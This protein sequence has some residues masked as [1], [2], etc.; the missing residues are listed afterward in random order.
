MTECTMTDTLT[1]QLRIF[2]EQ[3]KIQIDPDFKIYKSAAHALVD[4][5]FSSMAKFDAV[6]KPLMTRLEQHLPDRHM[7]TLSELV[8]DIDALGVEKYAKEVLNLQRISGRLK[9]QIVRDA[10]EFLISQG[11]ETKADFADLSAREAACIV[12]Y[13]L[14]DT[15]RGIGPALSR[16]L[17][18]LLGRENYIKPD[19]ILTRLLIRISVGELKPHDIKRMTDAIRTVADEMDTTPARLDNALWLYES[20]RPKERDKPN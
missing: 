16:Y 12:L 18:L 19:T 3:E 9:V 1:D 6:V 5:V 17:M 11:I 14:V 7:L 4:C 13:E 10:A 8:E 2:V 20:Q 15:V